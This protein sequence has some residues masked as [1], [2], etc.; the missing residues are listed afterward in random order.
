MEKSKKAAVIEIKQKK[1]LKINPL[2][3]DRAN[4]G[5][6]RRIA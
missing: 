5:A 3:R 4:R 1:N 6:W 2:N